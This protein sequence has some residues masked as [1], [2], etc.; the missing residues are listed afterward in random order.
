MF[1]DNM[2]KIVILVAISSLYLGMDAGVWKYARKPPFGSSLK[3]LYIIPNSSIVWTAGLGWIGKSLDAGKT[4][5]AQQV[6]GDLWGV[7]FRNPNEGLACGYNGV[8]LKTTDGGTNWNQISIPTTDNLIRISFWDDSVGLIAGG[9]IS[10]PFY[11]IILRTTDF[12]DTWQVVYQG[13]Y[14]ICTDVKCVSGCDYAWVSLTADQGVTAVLRTTD[15]GLTWQEVTIAGGSGYGYS[16]DGADAGQTAWL[17]TWYPNPTRVYKTTDGGN[18]WNSYDTDD[19]IG[20]WEMKFLDSS[21][22]CISCGDMSMGGIANVMTTSDGGATW[23]TADHPGHEPLYG[24]GYI[25]A[26]TL[27]AVGGCFGGTVIRST[28]SG[29]NWRYETQ[30]EGINAFC[31]VDTEYT[32]AAG[33][34]AT[35]LKSTD[36]GYTWECQD[37][38]ESDVYGGTFWCVSFCN[39]N[40]G[41]AS[42]SAYFAAAR[43]CKTTDGGH[44]WFP[45]ACTGLPN[46]AVTDM[47]FVT[48]DRG[49]VLLIDGRIYV[50][51]DGA[52]SF[53]LQH[54]PTNVGDWDAI[55]F[56]D[57]LNGWA[58]GMDDGEGMVIATTDGG[59][60]WAPQ[61]VP[62]DDWT[63]I[64]FIDANTGFAV[65]GTTFVMTA[66]GGDNWNSTTLPVSAYGV[67]FANSSCGWVNGSY[68]I[69]HTIDGGMTFFPDTIESPGELKLAGRAIRQRDNT[70]VIKKYRAGTEIREESRYAYFPRIV[71]LDTGHAYCGLGQMNDGTILKYFPSITGAAEGAIANDISTILGAVPNPFRHDTKIGFTLQDP[72]SRYQYIS[73]KIYDTAG[74]LVRD[75]T[76]DLALCVT[77]RGSEITW[78]GDDHSGRKLPPGVY[79]VGIECDMARSVE[80]VILTR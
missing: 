5:E 46:Q 35:I 57:S 71:A 66:D 56:V 59:A 4:W 50:T 54:Q 52:N 64:D 41:Y 38:V 33:D 49:W 63:D 10:W 17:A 51:Q 70:G 43:T 76:K 75:L 48:P 11:G 9:Y 14:E 1:N 28:D 39:R 72:W 74:R 16:I 6:T 42:G 62:Q 79:F 58:A 44:T 61:A 25:D 18:S 8:V 60:N 32:W 53:S 30:A 80:K 19:V 78:S 15:K 55:D 67:G 3:D 22:G 12:G 69:F 23:M 73:L 47:E 37:A 31:I 21:R 40:V 20:P 13:G 68:G 45:P 7:W 2:R 77:L 24:I 36:G 27:I 34:Y 29:A 26:D 65:G